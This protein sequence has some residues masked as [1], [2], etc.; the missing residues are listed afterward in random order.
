[1]EFPY[2]CRC[3]MN[4]YKKSQNNG[5]QIAENL[6]QKYLSASKE[7]EIKTI[8]IK[9]FSKLTITKINLYT[10]FY[11]NRFNLNIEIIMGLSQQYKNSFILQEKINTYLKQII[12]DIKKE[13]KK[14]IGT[15][16]TIKI[17]GHVGNYPVLF[18][19]TPELAQHVNTLIKNPFLIAQYVNTLIKEPFLYKNLPN[20][21]KKIPEIQKACI[22]GWIN[23]LQK[24][25]SFYPYCPFKTKPEIL[26]AYKQGLNFTIGRFKK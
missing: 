22:Q 7:L 11:N 1:M 19:D 16:P 12:K 10:T 8:I 18:P 25:P 20:R 5:D 4:W 3:F 26:N 24:N 9:H 2:Y 15:S 23:L 14:S 17:K 21:W 13:I 6:Y